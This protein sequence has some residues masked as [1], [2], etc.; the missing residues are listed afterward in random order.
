M[1]MKMMN[2]HTICQPNGEQIVNTVYAR[3]L[4]FRICIQRGLLAGL[5]ADRLCFSF[6]LSNNDHMNFESFIEIY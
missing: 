4:F 6:C 2:G 5:L 1:Y 3:T